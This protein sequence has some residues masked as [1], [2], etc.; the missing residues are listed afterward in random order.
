MIV[1]NPPYVEIDKSSSRKALLAEYKTC[2][3]NWSRDE[4]LYTLFVERS[5]SLSDPSNGAIGLILPL[6]V[7]FSTKR[8]FAALRTKIAASE[9]DWHWSHFDR[10]P[11]SLF[12]NDV[13]TRCSVGIYRTPRDTFN[14]RFLTTSLKRW[15][16]DE[17]ETLFDGLAY[18][19]FSGS[20]SDRIPKLADDAQAEGLLYLQSLKRP[21]GLQLG[22][23]V[24]ANALI[25]AAPTFP[26]KSV[27]VAGT[28][29]NWF[30]AWRSIPTTTDERGRAS[31]PARAIGFQFENEDEA[32][33]VFALLCS[34][35]GYWWWA[36]ASDG[37]NLKKWLVE[38]FPLAPSAI[39]PEHRARLSELGAQLKSDLEGNYV[40]KDNQGRKGNFYL[41]ACEA[42][43]KQIDELIDS[44]LSG[45]NA[46]FIGSVQD[47]NSTFS[48]V[49]DGNLES[50]A[51]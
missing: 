42:I 14:R 2:L 33:V 18:A 19:S 38:S 17:R 6:S 8:P 40:Y 12:G 46:N 51:D 29:Y 44:A 36:V 11:S 47:F 23:V 20:I 48:R 22:R 49:D 31:V 34:S 28:A 27:F 3:N 50:D 1:G 30:P 45:I 7:A 13:R 4:D 9:G 35:L 10:I 16:V 32:N 43:T 24:S 21:L 37:F 15:S 5:L 25:E 39:P 41:P 26:S